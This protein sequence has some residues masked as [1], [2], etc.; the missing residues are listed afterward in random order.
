MHV[1]ANTIPADT[2]F[3]AD[4]CIVGAGAAGLTIARELAR[5][6]L[7][8]VVLE[9]GGFELEPDIQTLYEGDSIGLK[10]DL[11]GTRLRYFGGSTN[12]WGG[13]CYPLDRHDFD[14]RDWLPHS[15]WPFDLD[16][17]MPYYHRAHAICQLGPFDYPPGPARAG[18]P[19]GF[20]RGNLRPLGNKAN[21]LRFGQAYR[22]ELVRNP[23]IRVV[24]HA[25]VLEFES[26]PN[27]AR[28]TR[29]RGRAYGGAAFSVN[30]RAYV[31]ATGGVENARLLL[32]SD[33]TVSAGLGNQH[34][35]VGRFFQEHVGYYLSAVVML[36]GEPGRG[37]GKRGGR[38]ITF[39]DEALVANKL[40]NVA[41]EITPMKLPQ[42]SVF[43]RFS[44]RAERTIRGMGP[45]PMNPRYWA[46]EGKQPFDIA[47]EA[48]QA[49]NP[50]S[51]VTLGTQR[52][53]LGQRRVV[54]DWRLTE[55]DRAHLKKGLELLGR[56][57]G[58]LGEGRLWI[59][60][61]VLEEWPPKAISVGAH[62]IGTTR[63]HDNPRKGVVD[64]NCRVHGTSNL[65]VAGSSVFPTSG[66]ANPTLT[67][68]ALAARLADHL[69][70]TL[71]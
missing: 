2:A 1:D 30:A 21:P 3:A 45:S 36:Q 27:A 49:P 43:E 63:M 10:Y 58:R 64:A 46:G 14:A 19:D 69:G 59:R 24:T 22:D 31:L 38:W 4:L 40:L 34:D 41:C 12:H 71:A 44:D 6:K 15:G 18:S 66:K 32:L 25:S 17:L 67:I 55:L 48:E 56:E 29:V 8:I 5:S 13:N 28:V 57:L 51:R 23:R 26:T 53:A 62:H 11:I 35:L 20:M 65:F 50:D 52:D 33:K 54:L 39:S 47:Y 68:V 60:P 61:R 9:S 70:D 16:E 42:L 37:G 7:D